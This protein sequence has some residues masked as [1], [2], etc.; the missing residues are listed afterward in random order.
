MKNHI[1]SLVLLLFFMPEAQAAD[2]IVIVDKSQLS[3]SH[4]SCVPVVRDNGDEVSISCDSIIY[5][6]GVIIRDQQ[7]NVLHQSTQIVGPS[8]ITIPVTGIGNGSEKS[9]ID[10]YYDRKHFYGEFDE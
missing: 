2:K 3:G 9:T 6:V 10:I 5:N 4:N 8:E 1:I 7:G